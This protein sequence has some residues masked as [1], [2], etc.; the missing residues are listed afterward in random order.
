MS[1]T[2]IFAWTILAIAV[3]LSPGPDVLLVFGHAT[4]SGR[5]AGLAAAAGITAGGLWY[6]LLCGFGFLSL[7][8]LSPMLFLTVKIAGGLYLAWIGFNLILGA[9]RPGEPVFAK[10]PSLGSPFRQGLFATV[11]NPKVALFYLAVL[12]QFTG[13]GERAPVYGMVLVAI[14]YLINAPWLAAVAVGGARAGA[15]LRHGAAMRW[16]EGLLGSLFVA[17]A[18]KLATAKP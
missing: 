11:L 16:I 3:S 14:H 10:T 15:A 13:S 8:T 17:L 18:A 9:L 4:K 6:V 1:E 12:P 7:L 2:T 5:R